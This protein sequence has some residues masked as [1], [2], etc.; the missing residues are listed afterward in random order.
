M[1]AHA[2][3]SNNISDSNNFSGSSSV[4]T[5][6]SL[7]DKVASKLSKKKEQHLHTFLIYCYHTN[8][9]QR[10]HKSVI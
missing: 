2:P 3:F 10:Q 6:T 5:I 7:C 9:V 4:D 1:R 8:G